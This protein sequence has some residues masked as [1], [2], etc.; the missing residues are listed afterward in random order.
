MNLFITGTDTEVGK[1]LVTASLLHAI[2]AR[3]ETAVGLKPVA[4]GAERTA[5]GL[6]NEDGLA[7]LAASSPGFHYDQINPLVLEPA[8]APHIAAEEVE[9]D[10]TV[11]RLLA[12]ITPGPSADWRLVEG[13]GG[14]RVP[15]SGRETME[16]LALALAY[17]VVLVVALRLGCLNHAMLTADRI[18]Q[19]GLPLAGWIATEPDPCQSRRDENFATLQQWLPAPCLGRLPWAE[20]PD[21][22]RMAGL[23]DLSPLSTASQPARP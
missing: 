15:L 6:R 20:S 1:T 4:S 8:I 9:V 12:G 13:V 5:E 3:G 16:D 18:R 2:R 14:W 21:P 17:P 22:K 23:L 7:L 10:L 19:V 11:E